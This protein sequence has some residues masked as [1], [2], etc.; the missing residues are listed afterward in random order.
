MEIS[1]PDRI[2]PSSN[3]AGLCDALYDLQRV[4]L[5]STAPYTHPVTFRTFPN[6]TF[7]RAHQLN[8]RRR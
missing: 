7:F 8:S 6:E 4:E 3:D 1:D 5:P 2:L